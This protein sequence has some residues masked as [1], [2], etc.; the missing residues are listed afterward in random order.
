MRVILFQPRFAEL[1]KSGKKCQTIRKAARCRPGD[2][3][4]LRCWREKPYRS[5][6]VHLR[7]A[8]CTEVLPVTIGGGE[9]HDGLVLN[10]ESLDL[11]DGML[12]AEHFVIGLKRRA[13]AQADG[14]DSF[15]S[16]RTWFKEN[17]GLPFEGF[18]IRW[19][20]KEPTTKEKGEK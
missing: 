9:W 20:L 6:Q 8:T 5:T 18:A 15:H 7:E 3:L 4:S 13:L 2:L 11:Y 1:V 10:G 12:L 17:H 14:F 19:E 16:M